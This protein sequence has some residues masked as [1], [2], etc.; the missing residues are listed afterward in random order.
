MKELAMEFS[1]TLNQTYDLMPDWLKVC[2]WVMLGAALCYS[3]ILII[4]AAVSTLRERDEK[5]SLKETLRVFFEKTDKMDAAF[6]NRIK[7]WFRMSRRG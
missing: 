4:A 7:S 6:V 3:L 5:Q 2:M 1:E